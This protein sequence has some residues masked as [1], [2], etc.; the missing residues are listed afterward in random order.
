VSQADDAI[1]AAVLAEVVANEG[2]KDWEAW[3][4]DRMRLQ[5]QIHD[6]RAQR[7]VLALKLRGSE[8]VPD[9]DAKPR[10][11]PRNEKRLAMGLGALLPVAEATALLPMSDADGR[12]W[13]RREGLVGDADGREVVA[14]CR[15][16]E[17]PY[18]AE[19][20]V[21]VRPASKL[22]KPLPRVRLGESGRRG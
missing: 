14:W 21:L 19:A 9:G 22:R 20:E 17:A 12:R 15:V 8:A 11:L 18:K 4:R 6:L 3:T 5:E 16:V 1:T 7:N 2:D 10:R 13:L